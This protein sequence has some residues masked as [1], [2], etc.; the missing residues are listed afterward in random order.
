MYAFLSRIKNGPVARKNMITLTGT[1][2]WTLSTP[3][4][5]VQLRRR[6]LSSGKIEMEEETTNM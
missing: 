4:G 2:K 6:Y 5:N 3:T 1:N